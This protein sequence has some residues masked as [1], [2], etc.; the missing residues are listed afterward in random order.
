MLSFVNRGHE[1]ETGGKK[2]E[3]SGPFRF[4]CGSCQHHPANGSSLWQQ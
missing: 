2:G 1:R 3:R 4:A